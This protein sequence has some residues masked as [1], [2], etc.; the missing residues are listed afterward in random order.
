MLS[1]VFVDVINIVNLWVSSLF[2]ILMIREN[3]FSLW[4]DKVKFIREDYD[5]C[6]RVMRILY[7]VI[8]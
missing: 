7:I 6:S 1:V 4:E 8:C 5:R 2:L 3:L